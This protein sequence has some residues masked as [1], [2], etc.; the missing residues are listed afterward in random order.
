MASPVSPFTWLAIGLVKLYQWIIS[1]LL[2]PRCR[3]TPTCSQYALEAL[4]AHGF[5]KGCW[6]SGKRLLKCHPLSDG[7]YDP[8]P[9]IQ[10]QDRDN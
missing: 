2:G 8:V 9:P 4:K 10:K 3:F 6:L 1:P 5:A 7:G